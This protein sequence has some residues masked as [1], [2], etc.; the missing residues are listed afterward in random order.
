MSRTP[1]ISSSQAVSSASRPA[2]GHNGVIPNF[3]HLTTHNPA[4][5]ESYIHLYVEGLVKSGLDAPAEGRRSA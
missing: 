4:A 2:G 1:S 3:H 5:L